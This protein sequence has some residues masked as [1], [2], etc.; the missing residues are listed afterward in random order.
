MSICWNLGLLTSQ[1]PP[2]HPSTVPPSQTSRALSQKGQHYSP[3]TPPFPPS[4]LGMHIAGAHWLYWLPTGWLIIKAHP[5]PYPNSQ[6][7]SETLGTLGLGKGLDLSLWQEAQELH[8][9]TPAARGPCSCP[10]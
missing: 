4:P 6:S 5:C 1:C 2:Q 7:I 9:N 8:P 3:A 10:S